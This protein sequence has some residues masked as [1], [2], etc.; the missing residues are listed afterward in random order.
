ML[1]SASGSGALVHL[2]QPIYNKDSYDDVDYDVD[3]DAEDEDD[4]TPDNVL[5]PH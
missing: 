2:Q 1:H 4:M 3:G 5:V